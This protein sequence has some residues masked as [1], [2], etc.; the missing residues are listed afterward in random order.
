M[1]KAEQITKKI[2]ECD[3]AGK[4][5]PIAKAQLVAVYTE[6]HL[7]ILNKTPQY[8]IDEYDPTQELLSKAERLRKADLIERLVV[9]IE[10][11]AY[12]PE[13]NKMHFKSGR[14]HAT[15]RV[16]NVGEAISYLSGIL[17]DEQIV[18]YASPR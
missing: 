7:N 11:H 4:F 8:K 12:A 17:S 16:D 6:V 15:P 14:T 2:N 18:K 9:G 10:R 5:M 1:T 13:M 3:V